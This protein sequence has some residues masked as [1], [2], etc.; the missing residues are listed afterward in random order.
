MYQRTKDIEELMIFHQEMERKK[1]RYEELMQPIV[2]D[3]DHA[4]LIHK[5]ISEAVKDY[6]SY[7]RIRAELL[8]ALFLFQPE[9]L[10]RKMQ[11]TDTVKMYVEQIMEIET[12]MMVY[13]KRDLL[14]KATRDPLL[15][16]VVRKVIGE[17]MN[18]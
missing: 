12:N 8:I 1:K 10:F 4:I 17:I 3:K 11:Y 6:P 13:Y 7:I 18:K 16:S 15:S 14:Y 5:Q 9:A 2:V